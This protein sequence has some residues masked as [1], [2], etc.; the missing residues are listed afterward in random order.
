MSNTSRN[1]RGILAVAALTASVSWTVTAPASAGVAPVVDVAE[2]PGPAGYTT[3]VCDETGDV[4]VTAIG[5]ETVTPTGPADD[6]APGPA[7]RF[8]R[9]AG[10]PGLSWAAGPVSFTDAG[11]VAGGTGFQSLPY[12]RPYLSGSP[13]AGTLATAPD[14]PG[15]PGAPSTGLDGSQVRVSRI[16]DIPGPSGALAG[17]MPLPGPVPVNAGTEDPPSMDLPST[18]TNLPGADLNL[19]GTDLPSADTNLPSMDLPNA[20]TNLPGTVRLEVP[21]AP[22]TPADGVAPREGTEV[23]PLE[24][25]EK[26]PEPPALGTVSSHLGLG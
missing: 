1:V 17:D 16:Q 6:G 9:I 24:D 4:R 18:D 23:A 5:G 22:E 21:A 12:G 20:D 13:S 7:D 11:G 3:A 14:L 25:T 26:A 8:A 2:A 19:P 10:L 15:L